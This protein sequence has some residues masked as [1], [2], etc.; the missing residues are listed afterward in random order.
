[1][2]LKAGEQHAFQEIYQRYWYK[3]FRIAKRKVRAEEDAEEIIQDIFVDLWERRKQILIDELEKYLYTAVK[4]QILKYIKAKLV[5]Q[6]YQDVALCNN[7]GTDTQTEETLALQD[8]HSAILAGLENLPPKS[9]EIFRLNRLEG[10]SANEIAM[11]LQIPE[12][13]VEYHITQSLRLMRTYLKDFI[14]FILTFLSIR[15]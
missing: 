8:L 13:T 9:Q 11:L 5:R 15:F 3:L 10:R 1:M 6:A 12:R 4:Y 2:Q 14:W 7:P